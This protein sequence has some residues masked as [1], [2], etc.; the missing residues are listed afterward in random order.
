MPPQRHPEQASIMF[1]LLKKRD[2]RKKRKWKASG[3]NTEIGG[4]VSESY[5]FS[6]G[7]GGR[8]EKMRV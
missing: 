5:I 1:T 4:G 6:K 7:R 8:E 3:N 2:D